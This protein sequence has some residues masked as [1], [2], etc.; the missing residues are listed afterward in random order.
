MRVIASL[1]DSA[2]PADQRE[3]RLRLSKAGFRPA[4]AE[5][6]MAA[7]GILVGEMPDA[8]FRN[9][10]TRVRAHE[11]PGLA[12]LDADETRKIQRNRR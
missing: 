9:L 10:Q 8:E 5:P 2:T 6:E 11:V 7:L 3:A 1:D 12:S 4:K